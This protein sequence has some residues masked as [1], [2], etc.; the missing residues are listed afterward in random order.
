MVESHLSQMLHHARASGLSMTHENA[1]KLH[2]MLE[3]AGSP[4]DTSHVVRM[5]RFTDE[6]LQSTTSA[7]PPVSLMQQS[8]MYIHRYLGAAMW[9]HLQGEIS[10]EHKIWRF[11]AA[12][13]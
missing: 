4:F 9:Q 7:H 6:I 1:T 13:S 10:I 5:G 2:D 11:F 8:H 3:H 12:S